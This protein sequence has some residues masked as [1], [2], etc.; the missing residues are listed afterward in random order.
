MDTT[1]ALLEWGK[2]TQA[3]WHM[4]ERDKITRWTAR[5]ES[6]EVGPPAEP[7]PSNWRTEIAILLA[8]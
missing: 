2:R 5:L 4:T 7:N 3:K 6:Y 8:D 1:A